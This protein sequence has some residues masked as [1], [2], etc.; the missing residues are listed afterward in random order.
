[1]AINVIAFGSLTD[2]V[3]ERLS[4]ED[5]HDTN[6]LVNELKQRFPELRNAKYLVAVNKKM[7]NANTVLNPDDTIALMSPFSGG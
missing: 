7:I 6:A 1:M 2:I 5:I 3:G 4:L